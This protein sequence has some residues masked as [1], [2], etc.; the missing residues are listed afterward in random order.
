MT[1]EEIQKNAAKE[2]EALAKGTAPCIYVDTSTLGISAG[3]LKVLAQLNTE[4]KQQKIEANVIEVG[5]LGITYLEPVVAIA[6]PGQPVI[7]YGGVSPENITL[8]V[9]D[10]LAGS[11]LHAD[12]AFATAGEGDVA[13]IPKLAD[14]PFLKSQ[15]RIILRHS[16]NIAPDN[17]N[18]YVAVG[19]Y[20]G[21]DKALKTAPEAIIE[22]VKTSGLKGRGG[23]GFPTADKW[24]A[25]R[26]AAGTEKYL[27]CN[28]DEAD[29]SVYNGRTLLESDPHSVFEG[30]LIA[31]FAIGATHGYVY[32]NDEYE[33][34]ISRV[35]TALQQMREN[36][37]LGKN[38]AG[39]NF[40]FDIEIRKGA[41][42]FICGEESALIRSMEGNR[43]MPFVRPP[44]PAESGFNGKPTVVNDVETLAAVSFIFQKSA[45]EYA[46]YGTESKG[47][48][49]ITLSGKVAF[50]GLIEVPF[51]TTIR[52]I[53][54]DIGGGIPNGKDFKAALVGGPVGGLLTDMSLDTPYDYQSLVS[55]GAIV[56][57]GS[58][59]VADSDECMVELTRKSIAF[60]QT[61]SCGQCTLGRGGTAQI[62]EFLLDMTRGEAKP[63]DIETVRDLGE[64]MKLG[65]L[66]GLGRNAP[67][68][69]LTAL[70]NFSDEVS[71]HVG[72]KRC[73][74][75]ACKALINFYILPGN[76]QGCTKCLT[77]CP[78]KAI[79]GGEKLIHVI[80]QKKCTKC[81]LCFE[82]C[83]TE[84]SAVNKVTGGRMPPLPAEPVAVGSF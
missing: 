57:T 12:M 65:A 29:P 59:Y 2:W 44:Y 47:T 71:A 53:I 61:H 70:N 22:E 11:E 50:P 1:F 45:A 30:M 25:C 42:A 66:C 74:A 62:K 40:N 79:A 32:I 26:S 10:Y 77:V 35:E 34:A 73:P 82:A 49:L 75:K 3:A 84:Y 43:G 76:C 8:L 83:P 81:G 60:T 33:L 24:S 5:S 55:V 27:I 56:G 37:L 23:A 17:L 58:I 52:Q 16:G 13:G 38:I 15:V 4:L 78:E 63:D 80:D 21:L 51:G 14:L 41:G 67:N 9:K 64:A 6:K 39:S 19:G 48:K 7:Y 36:G 18:H 20:T 68:P 72:R 54:Y 28:A 31:A 46:G 69:V